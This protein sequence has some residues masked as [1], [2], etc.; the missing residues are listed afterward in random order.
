MKRAP[1]CSPWFV[2]FLALCAFVTS[3]LFVYDL[4]D[5]E[6]HDEV[7]IH[8]P[9]EVGSSSGGGGK[10]VTTHASCAFCF[11]CAY[12]ATDAAVPETTQILYT[13]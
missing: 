13:T 1:R 9:P 3:S 8:R 10:A 12:C 7:H 11:G 5:L 4:D 6:G 2:G